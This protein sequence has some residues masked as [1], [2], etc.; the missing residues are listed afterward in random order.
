MRPIYS[1][2][3]WCALALVFSLPT[4]AQTGG[5]APRMQPPASLWLEEIGLD[6]FS[7][8]RGRP[9]AGRTIRDQPLILGGVEYAHGIGTRS[10]SEFVV[11]LHGGARRFESMVGFDDAVR[12]GVGSVTFEVWAD[13]ALVAQSGLMRAG[14]A[15]KPLSADLRGARVLTLLVDDGG[16]TSND[17]EVAWAGAMISLA[18]PPG[19]KPE[20]YTPP[21]ESPAVIAP[22][23]S[24]RKP[25]LHGPRITGGTPG[26]P[27]LFRVPASGEGPLRFRARG[28]PPG[29]TIDPA[30]G[31]I[32]G[33]P[34]AAG[35]H[36]V[37]LE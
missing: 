34:R 6:T 29:L 16:D 14:D 35:E 28:L 11:D 13:D 8:R 30:T 31:I 17:D 20:A 15:P 24:A 2:P 4:V 25:A 1:P 12:A 3:A 5:A 21:P 18:N 33:S 26:R 32:A 9:R 36:R 22:L 10:I 23:L 7:Q 37:K 19:P 27:F